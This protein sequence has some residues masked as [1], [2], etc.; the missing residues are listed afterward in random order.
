VDTIADRLDAMVVRVTG[1]GARFTA[2]LRDRT[3]VTVRFQPGNY[4][5]YDEE[6]LERHLT[7]VAKLLWAGR[8]REYYAAKSEAFGMSITHESPPLT[9]RDQDY[10]AERDRM[11][12]EGR[13][14]DGLVSIS[15]RGMQ[16]WTVRI[17]PGTLRLLDEH[18]FAD[19]VRAAAA[20]LIHD[21]FAGIARLKAQ[22]Y[23]QGY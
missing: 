9:A 6:L 8:M 10:D 4:E 16:A 11:V 3:E 17:A 1:P 12:A 18:Q 23:T 13:S 5:E 19:R 2:E 22:I 20:A 15:V 21:Q 7:A 14:A